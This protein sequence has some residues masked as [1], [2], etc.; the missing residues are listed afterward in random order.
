MKKLIGIFAALVFSAATPAQEI[1][2]I[3]TGA[4]TGSVVLAAQLLEKDA[5]ADLLGGVK[6]N[7][8]IPGDACKAFSMVVDSQFKETFVTH[9]DN[10]YNA[11]AELK[12]NP[13][14]PIPDFSRAVPVVTEIQ[15]LFLVMPASMDV[16]SLHTS[17]L[18]T[19]YAFDNPLY[20][21]WHTQLNQAFGQDHTFVGYNGSGSLITGLVSGEID[22]SW[23]TWSSVVQINAAALRKFQVVYQTVHNQN[24][25]IEKSS[26]ESCLCKQFL[27]F[28]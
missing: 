17:K 16:K 14:C 27:D 25:N 9:S 4:R 15:G 13:L 12:R 20:R 18:K 8:S 19:G 21:A 5:Q 2:Y 7:L 3:V 11:T 1:N 10:L 6:L 23:L 22:V 28:Q 26:I 24:N